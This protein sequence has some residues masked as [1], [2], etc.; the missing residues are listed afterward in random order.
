MNFF[1]KGILGKASLASI[2]LF[3]II[4]VLILVNLS[5]ADNSVFSFNRMI[6]CN[7]CSNLEMPSDTKVNVFLNM[8][9]VHFK[10]EDN[11]L[12]L[13][14]SIPSAFDI[15]DSDGGTVSESGYYK[16][17]EWSIDL[18]E[19]KKIG[20]DTYEMVEIKKL[21]SLIS[22]SV[23]GNE[24]FN[25]ITETEKKVDSTEFLIYPSGEE[26]KSIEIE[27]AEFSEEIIGHVDDG[28]NY[29]KRVRIRTYQSKKIYTDLPEKIS[30]NY[31]VRLYHIKNSKKIDVTDDP[32]YNVSL[33]DTDKDGVA[34]RL[35]W[36][37]PEN[38][39]EIFEIDASIKVIN[40]QSYPVVGG[41][42]TVRFETVG[43]D[44][45]TITAIDGTHFG[46]DLEFLEIRCG[47]DSLDYERSGS[48]ILIQDYNCDEIGYETSKV[49]TP[50]KHSLEFCFGDICEEAYNQAG[51]YEVGVEEVSGWTTINLRNSYTQPVVIAS[52]QEGWDNRDEDELLSRPVVRNVTS[53]SFEVSVLDHEGDNMTTDVGYI[54]ME[55]GHHTIEG[56]EVEA[57]LYTQSGAWSGN[58]ITF[59]TSFSSDSVSVVDTCQ[60]DTGAYAMTSRYGTIDRNGISV[61]WEGWDNDLW[62]GTTTLT[63]GYIAME[64]GN[65]TYFE[66]GIEYSVDD[67]IG[68]GQGSSS[69]GIVEEDD[70]E[71][72]D[73]VG[74]YDEKPVLFVNPIASGGTDP[75]ITG[76]W[77]LSETGFNV[78]CAEGSAGDDE[79]AHATND[80]PWMIWIAN[81]PP[82]E[83]QKIQCDGS[84]NCN[85]TVNTGVEVNASGSTDQDGDSITYFVEASL[86]VLKISDDQEPSEIRFFGE[87][88]VPDYN[89]TIE[90]LNPEARWLLNGDGTD[91]ADGHDD[92]GGNLPSFVSSIIPNPPTEYCG[93]FDGS[94]DELHI[95][96]DVNINTGSSTQKA[97]SV[98]IVADTIDGSGGGRGIWTE[99]GTGT[100]LSFYTFNNGTSDN[101][102]CTAVENSGTYIDWVGY[103]INEGS[104]YHIGCM[105]DFAGG[106]ID[107]YINGT[108]VASDTSL[109]VGSD[110]GSHG[111]NN[112]LGGVDQNTLNHSGGQISGNF[113]GRIADLV[114]WTSGSNI[115]QENFTAIYEAGAGVGGGSD[116]DATKGWETYSNI[117]ETDWESMADINVTVQISE[118]NN[119]GSGLN[120]NSYPDLQLEMYN[121][122]DWEEVGNFSIDDTGN[123]TLTTI[124]SSILSSWLDQ[125][126]SD[127]RIR[128][129][130][131][132]WNDPSNYDVINY[133]GIWVS[134]DGIRWTEIGNHTNETL[135]E[136]NT[137][138]L[139]EQNCVDF[140]ARAIDFNGSVS[141]S[142]Y[143]TKGACL[144]I[145]H[146]D[147][148]P[149]KWY[150]NST[151]VASGSQYIEDR[152]YQFNVTWNDSDTSVNKVLIEHN[153]SG[154][155]PENHTVSTSYGDVYYFDVSDMAAGTYVWREFAN[156]TDGFWNVTNS[157]EYWNYVIAKNSSTQ[158][159]MNLTIGTGT[160]G[161][162][163]NYQGTYPVTTNATGWHSSILNDQDI[164]FTLYR[165][166]SIIGSSNPQSN[167]IKLGAGLYVYTYNTSGNE[168]YTSS[169][170]QFNLTVQQNTTNPINLYFINS[171]GGFVNHNMTVSYEGQTN[172]TGYN[173]YPNSGTVH[174]FR[175]EVNVTDTEYDEWMTLGYNAGGYA[176][177]INTS[178]NENYSAN[179]TG[180]TYYI[181]V[182]KKQTRTYLWIND[183]RANYGLTASEYANFTVELSGYA[184]RYVELWSN[185]S[186]GT[187]RLWESGSS[188]IENITQ[189]DT[190]GKFAFLGN[191]SGNEN[192][193]Y[194]EEM[195]MLT[196]SSISLDAFMESI[197]PTS[198]N[199]SQNSTVVGNCSCDI[200]T[201][202][203]VYIEIQADGSPI[204]SAGGGD[205]QVNGS[206]SY[207]LGQLSSGWASRSWNI[208]GWMPGTYSITIKCNSTETGNT[209]S[210]AQNLEVNDTEKPTWS[211]NVTL[212]STGVDY[213]QGSIYHFNLT[214]DD[215]KEMDTVLIEH[216]FSGGSP[217][218]DTVPANGGN[219]YYYY[220]SDLAAGTYVW[221]EFGND[222]TDNWNVTDSWTFIVDKSPTDVN[223]YL[224]GSASDQNSYYPNSTVNVTAVSNVSSLYVQIWRN[225]TLISNG[226]GSVSNV[227]GW[228]AWNNNFTAQ[229][230]G[231][232]NYTSSSPVYLW[233]NVSKGFA[234]LVLK[235]N[236]SWSVT[237]PTATNVTASGCP[238]Q[239]TCNLYRNDTGLI[240]SNEDTVL[241]GSGGYDYVYNTSGGENYSANST[242]NILEVVKGDV[243][244]L[245][246]INT[247]W[248]ETYPTST[249]V[250]CSVSSL[251][252]EVSCTL[253][254]NDTGS[255]GNPDEEL[256][257]G[258]VY[259]YVTNTSETSNYSAN[260][261]GDVM[262]LTIEPYP[263]TDVDMFFN[264]TQ[265]NYDMN[266]DSGLNVTVVLDN[267]AIG[268][269]SIW[270]NYSDGAWKLWDSCTDCS[271][272][273]NESFITD[274]GY[275]NFTAN[276][277]G[278]QNYSPSYESWYVN[279]KDIIPPFSSSNSTNS[280]GAG[281]AIEHRLKWEDNVGL[282]GYIF[283]FCN[284]TWDGS[285]CVGTEGESL[286]YNDTV[287][288]LSPSYRWLLDGDGTDS[289]DTAHS[290]GGTTPNWV[291]NIIPNNDTAQCADFTG[292]QALN[293]P[294]RDDINGQDTYN[295]SI[296]VWIVADTIDNTTG[297]G[298]IIWEEGGGTNSMALYVL[299]NFGS[300]QIFFSV[301]ESANYDYVNY[302]LEEGSFVHVG[303]SLDCTSGEMYMYINGTLVDSKTGGLNIGPFFDSHGDDPSIGGLDNA[304]DRHDGTPISGGFDGRIA[305]LVYWAEPDRVLNETDFNN[306]Y[307]AG[308]DPGSN[309]VSDE[310]Q[311][312]SG[313]PGWSNVTKV[314][315]STD[316]AGIAWCVYSNDSSDNWD[317]SSCDDPFFYDTIGYGY[318]E[319][320]L[321]TPP[322]NTIIEDYNTFTVNA[323]VF[324]RD[325]RCG[326][327]YGT[328][329]YNL[330]SLY[331]DTPV[332][333]TFGDEPFF[334]NET[335]AY[336][337]K[338][339]M[340]DMQQ[341]D[342]CNVTWLIN[343]TEGETEWEM[344]VLFNSSYTDFD[345]NTT[346]NITIDIVYCIEE[347]S[348]HFS[349][350]DFGSTLPSTSGNDALGNSVNDYNITNSGTCVSNVWI[351]A[352]SLVNESDEINYTNV[353]FNN[354]TDDYG[355][356]YRITND[357]GSGNST[358]KKNVLGST[359][360]TSYYFLDVP[361]V[362]AKNYAGNITI[363]LNSTEYDTLCE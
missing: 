295:K 320:S 37:S 6:V 189:M 229:V 184:G 313:Y 262:I 214:W 93:D 341:D 130:N 129:V 183:T 10:D 204:P 171:T 297:N 361:A 191:Y 285:N 1:K 167:V 31:V 47:D 73:F 221:R 97:I 352:S 337:L 84:D 304:A 136:W 281:M 351:K 46:E 311:L 27:M 32:D 224:N 321:E 161:T 349:S 89:G 219:E 12:V 335:P 139:A 336:A 70:F 222:T 225:G 85:I 323:T 175:D 347:M 248:T 258:G 273:Q 192:Y 108:L 203:D 107:M 238:S 193:T 242:S 291:D 99:G 148:S 36:E 277:S 19:A 363:C 143:F 174:L 294:D 87:Q 244:P 9:V 67:D 306:I 355:S 324:C 318:L 150:E 71:R 284:G 52:V 21:Y 354:A 206:S 50:G 236:E 103:P 305:D 287:M 101:V 182:N 14:E 56:T 158:D 240:G 138:D 43:T 78:T 117:L 39:E 164:T 140:R 82:S 76:I 205:L 65:Y 201:C 115:T 124:T 16:K 325:G 96:D 62:P 112:A 218:N 261:T 188:P 38:S 105:Y 340:N 357:Y 23:D 220:L 18:G 181:I 283:R 259:E 213:E 109:A 35:E 122:S 33:I 348:L 30:K 253:F 334:V 3:I 196:V 356:S 113:D 263:F 98:W 110:L 51:D 339:C 265:N 228:P 75:T 202:N 159:F 24:K 216:N 208:S 274:S 15:V 156:N 79:Q 232:E 41:E 146:A 100:S 309:W 231:N 237:Y 145:S 53:N 266:F 57:G 226:T 8:S 111:N 149:P 342:F 326:D 299:D 257:G 94:N 95:P 212:P 20:Y 59:N 345:G 264:G 17:I 254:R 316:G 256:L 163:E 44:D 245:L 260:S 344:G 151:S 327:V 123:F 234:P 230:L 42:W 314:V 81:S 270:T 116:T 278:D 308:I 102:Y 307:Q 187:W 165:N 296:S 153:F 5:V 54:V 317:Y 271:S 128:G 286:D 13:T 195:W 282:S 118:Y 250:S 362:Y 119:I 160:S 239:V 338:S 190:T 210:S 329:R 267:P 217:V 141:Y 172:V 2:F 353:S 275:W 25:F 91:S 66:A 92:S 360:V 137:T 180:V 155:S 22:P 251:N 223:L 178:G 246:S 276:Y 328:V 144:N 227:T 233:W 197:S 249:N 86:E 333:T 26:E 310:W 176:Y 185:Y 48:S 49:L 247:S 350:I 106:R 207:S 186:D 279:V 315:N 7:G 80:I 72:V 199:Q 166:D 88:F 243:Q 169:S 4:F 154:G 173:I 126:N 134:A 152:Q 63:M 68:E 292:S 147:S 90:D 358:L 346:D 114:Y 29:V 162:E 133:T 200:G 209:F 69:A 34:D 359:N 60:N 28:K 61:Y 198:I 168:N 288:G 332:N 252:D 300:D 312:F 45:L 142:N 194:S 77:N 104:L 269:I 215:N 241:L 293:L 272:L 319:V 120:G 83:P 170:K 131:F 40:V 255:V 290:D 179:D 289:I 135:I 64:I 331:P 280:S 301:V 58:T 303:V 74:V 343:A 125:E 127:L 132:D 302:T 330:T 121:G 11:T 157:G 298:R 177:K 268:D 322:G 211:G 235:I 55:K